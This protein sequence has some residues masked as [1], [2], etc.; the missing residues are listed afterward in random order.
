MTITNVQFQQNTIVAYYTDAN[1]KEVKYIKVDKKDLSSLT[2]KI[3]AIRN[4]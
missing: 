2:D 4:N 3:S 1:S